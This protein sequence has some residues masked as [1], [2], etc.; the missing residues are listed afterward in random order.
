[1]VLGKHQG[2]LFEFRGLHGVGVDHRD[3]DRERMR[4]GTE[5]AGGGQEGNFVEVEEDGGEG[6]KKNRREE[7][8]GGTG[9]NSFEEGRQR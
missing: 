3:M 4:E 6:P 8:E 2:Q 1:M 7:E 5:E 9:R